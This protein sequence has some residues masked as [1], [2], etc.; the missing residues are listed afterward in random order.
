MQYWL[1]RDLVVTHSWGENYVADPTYWR[2]RYQQTKNIYQDKNIPTPE[3]VAF[4]DE[5]MTLVTKRLEKDLSTYLSVRD[6]EKAVEIIN[7][8]VA[9][10]K[11]VWRKTKTPEKGLPRYVKAFLTPEYEF[12]KTKDVNDYLP[13]ELKKPYQDTQ[14]L[15]S[16][17][18]T[19][20]IS[21]D[22]ESGIGFADV[23]LDNLLENSQG[24]LFFIDVDKPE[25]VHWLTMLGQIHADAKSNAPNSVFFKV[26]TEKTVALTEDSEMQR[27]QLKLGMMNRLLLPCTLRNLSYNHELG[28]ET[29]FEKIGNNL[30]EVRNLVGK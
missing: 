20:V 10:F 5:T 26:L 11:E 16:E 2:R 7:K 17:F 27:Q 19:S 3:L 18:V 4:H 23:K 8:I 13:D 22:Y 28:L 15:L 14:K 12:L 29:N 30:A 25:K 6:D 24:E 21:N 1:G 9:L